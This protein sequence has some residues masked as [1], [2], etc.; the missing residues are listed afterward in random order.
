[1]GVALTVLSACGGARP[2]R[3][4]APPIHGQFYRVH[5]GDT[6]YSIA[7]RSGRDYHDLAR[8]NGISPP[9]TI[10][11]G[12]L[13]R[14]V[15]RKRAVKTRARRDPKVFRK[16]SKKMLKHRWRWPLKGVIVRNF[17]ATGRKGIDIAAPPGT[18]VRAAAPGKVVYS[19]SGLVGY[20][21][22]VIV[23]HGE[24]YLSAYGNNRRLRVREGQ[25]VKAGQVIGEV[26]RGSDGRAVLHFEI[27]RNGNPVDPLRMLPRR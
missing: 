26:G 14:L 16:K 19:G 27:R 23:K 18:P 9:Y 21:K 4:P 10:Y 25:R 24:T 1:M 17:A 15:P 2:V 12:Q 20:G 7:R 8:W 11:P 22:L 6:L 13:L 3:P 5:P